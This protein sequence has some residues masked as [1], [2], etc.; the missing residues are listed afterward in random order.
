MFFFYVGRP[1]PTWDTDLF[2]LPETDSGTDTDS[3]SCPVQK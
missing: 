1:W 3:H 2:T